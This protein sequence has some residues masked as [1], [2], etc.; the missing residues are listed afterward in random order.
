ML[1]LLLNDGESPTFQE[2]EAALRG[3]LSNKADPLFKAIQGFFTDHHRKILNSLLRTIEM[4]ESEIKSV[5]AHMRIIQEQYQNLIDLL[6]QVPGISLIS[7]RAI[8]AETGPTLAAFSTAAA[9]ASW[10]GLCPGNNE[11][12]GKRHSGKTRVKKHWLKTIMVE[13]A[14]AAVKKKGSYYKDKYYRL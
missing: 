4:L 9:F 5:N 3:S 10:A 8:L 14:W 2:V 6:V 7:A 1:R 11:S 12:A 13:V